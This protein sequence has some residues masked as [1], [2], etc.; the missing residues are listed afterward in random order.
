[1]TIPWE[2]V[3]VMLLRLGLVAL[4]VPFSVYYMLVDLKGANDMRVAREEIF[5]PTLTV[6]PFDD[7]TD[8]IALANDTDFGLAAGNA[9]QDLTKALRVASALKAGTCWI[10]SYNV[11]DVTVSFGGVKRSGYGRECGQAAME[12]Y[13]QLKS[14]WLPAEGDDI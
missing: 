11:F 12:N 8:A 9:T 1:M 5:G 13:T 2:I 3:L 14:I 6:I 7:E 4:F 10:N